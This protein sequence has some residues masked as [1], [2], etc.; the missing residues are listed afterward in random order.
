MRKSIYSV[1]VVDSDVEFADMLGARV[2]SRG[3]MHLCAKAY[4]GDVVLPIVQ[5]KRPDIIIIFSA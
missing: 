1:L 2:V 4:S 3:N 5:E